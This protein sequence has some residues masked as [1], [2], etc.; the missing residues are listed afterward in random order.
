MQPHEKARR[1][2][3]IRRGARRARSL[4][5]RRTERHDAA[6]HV[7]LSHESASATRRAQYNTR[8]YFAAP[9][10]DIVMCIILIGIT[11]IMNMNMIMTMIRMMMM[12]INYS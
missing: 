7:A 1:Q 6:C 12:M 10:R 9:R 4:P 3:R 2:W 11:M 5:R 8:R